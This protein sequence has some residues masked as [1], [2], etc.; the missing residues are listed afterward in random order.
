MR[1][2]VFL[3][4][5]FAYA[6]VGVLIYS[7]VLLQCGLGPESPLA[8]NERVDK[9]LPFVIPGLVIVYIVGSI[10]FWGRRSKG[11]S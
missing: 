4:A 3:I 2:T 11:P 10:L 5:S 6:F 7:Q 1:L 8:C 9:Q